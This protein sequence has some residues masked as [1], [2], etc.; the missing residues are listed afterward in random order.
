[1]QRA[2]ASSDM[3]GEPYWPWVFV[4]DR[5]KASCYQ[6]AALA[7]LGDLP[8]AAAAYDAAQ[9]A[10]TRAKPRALAQ[11]DQARVLASAG[12]YGEGCQLAADALRTGREYGSERII[13]RVRDFRA[14]LPARTVEAHDLDDALASLYDSDTEFM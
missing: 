10:L 4:F 9:P 5:A 6:A 1:M 7:H 8:A 14:A 11:L 13:M 3:G 12:R 2:L